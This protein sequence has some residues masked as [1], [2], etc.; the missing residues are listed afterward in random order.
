MPF[1][2]LDLLRYMIEL[3]AGYNVVIPRFEDLVE[4]LHAVYSRAC[5][6]PIEEQLRAGNLRLVAF[7]SKV[8]VRYVGPSELERFAAQASF[9]NVNT[10]EDLQRARELARD[11]TGSAPGCLQGMRGGWRGERKPSAGSER[12]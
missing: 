3:S 4:P 10:P 7:N 6:G 8:R 11:R 1:L 2:N 12:H 5:L 9:L